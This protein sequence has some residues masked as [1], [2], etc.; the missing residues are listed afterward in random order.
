MCFA[1][2]TKGTAALLLAIRALATA[3]GVDDALLS[4]WATSMP[5]LAGQADA[6]ASANAPK[7]WRFAGELEEIASGFAANGLPAGFGAAAAD[8]YERLAEFKGT[9]D[10]TVAEVIGALLRRG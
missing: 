7:A 4:E 6:A 10:T 9:S 1:A 8:V 2:W 5:G 3:E